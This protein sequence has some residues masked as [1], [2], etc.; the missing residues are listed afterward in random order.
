MWN[1]YNVTH[2][3]LQFEKNVVPAVGLTAGVFE[4]P[5]AHTN[6]VNNW[7][8]GGTIGA[9]FLFSLFVRQIIDEGQSVVNA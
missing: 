6:Q 5:T 4:A 3:L 7:N 2:N 1:R 8:I 9:S